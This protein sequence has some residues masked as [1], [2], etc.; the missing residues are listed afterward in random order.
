MKIRKFVGLP[1]AAF[2]AVGIGMLVAPPAPAHEADVGQVAISEVQKDLGVGFNPD[3][4]GQ[5]DVALH[6]IAGRQILA[7]QEAAVTTIVTFAPASPMAIAANQ[8]KTT[9]VAIAA[10]G[11]K[12]I[13]VAH[14]QIAKTS[15]AEQEVDIAQKAGGDAS[16]LKIV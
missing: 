6:A 11:V 12:A 15:A 1:L 9:T 16:A 10:I 8:S 7:V 5:E 14:A 3:T 2:L 4:L 13:P